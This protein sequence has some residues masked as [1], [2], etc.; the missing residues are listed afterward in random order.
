VDLSLQE[1]MARA[2]TRYV[3][4][5]T[6]HIYCY[7]TCHRA[8]RI[9]GPHRVPFRAPAEAA[10]AGYRPCKICRPARAA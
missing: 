8:R 5:D 9:A 4:S 10:A 3:G 6:T 2:G 7:P 1:R